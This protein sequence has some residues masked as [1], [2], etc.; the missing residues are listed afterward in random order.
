MKK[1]YMNPELLVNT[2]AVADV[3]TTDPSIDLGEDDLPFDSFE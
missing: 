3:I 2:F 1:E